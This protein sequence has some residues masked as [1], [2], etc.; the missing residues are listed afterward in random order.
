[1]YV[2]KWSKKNPN[3][4]GKYQRFVYRFYKKNIVSSLNEFS[5]KKIK[6]IETVKSFFLALYYFSRFFFSLSILWSVAASLSTTCIG[7]SSRVNAAC[8]YVP[9]VY[10]NRPWK[11][12]PLAHTC[13]RECLCRYFLFYF[14]FFFY[15]I[16][17]RMERRRT[18]F[19]TRGSSTKK[20]TSTTNNNNS[21]DEK[22]DPNIYIQF[23]AVN[24]I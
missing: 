23:M 9:T 15:F 12:E 2:L 16:I 17:V 6:T 1:M 14:I 13:T 3:R 21:N 7:R 11:I 10:T 20:T 8:R 24:I 5:T 4:S 22:K 18:V 19:R